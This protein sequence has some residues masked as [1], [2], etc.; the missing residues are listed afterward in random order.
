MARV[1]RDMRAGRIES[2]DGTRLAYVL[3]QIGKLIEA[4]EI[5]KRLEAVEVVLKNRRPS[6]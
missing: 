4:G 1:Y 6:K 5:E 3:S 2:Q